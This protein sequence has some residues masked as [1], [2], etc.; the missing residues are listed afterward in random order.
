MSPDSPASDE[1]RRFEEQYRSQPESLVFARLADAY[2]KA[3]QP[4]RALEVLD[5]G[6]LRHPDYPS[7]H[8]V[9]ARALRDLG[10][11]DETLESFRRV[12]ELDGA[13]LV[14]IRELAGLADERGDIRE[15]RHW[16]ERLAHVDPANLEV[17]QR[18][19]ELDAVD[20][21]SQ[22]VERGEIEGAD[23]AS[24]DGD[25]D[26]EGP[27]S[28]WDDSAVTAAADSATGDPG[29][30]EAPGPAV[31][32][33]PADEVRPEDVVDAILNGDVSQAVRAEDTW[34]YEEETD[35]GDPE[36]S[37]DADLLTRTMAD[38]YTEQGLHREAAEIYRELLKDS[39]GD[40]ELVS[41][42]EA[43]REKA[44][45]PTALLPAGDDGSM[46]GEAGEDVEETGDEPATIGRPVGPPWVD[47]LRRL[48]RSGEER[49]GQL[50]EPET[51][52][53]S[54]GDPST[55]ESG[56]PAA[57]PPAADPPDSGKDGLSGSDS[58]PVQPSR[59]A[60]EWIQRL[61][62]EG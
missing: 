3:G 52:D 32:D 28:W 45:D 18:L 20:A 25:A 24:A 38:L 31:A 5:E 40:P 29:W 14:A 22:S 13:N 58:D 8:I 30:D 16:Y 56:Q 44:E 19:R 9:R 4:E 54:P 15:A 42:L 2:R 47:E 7:G 33:D 55:A 51:F 36:P 53:T 17:R 49:A 1:I 34:W 43:V 12:L 39:P 46:Q 10:R 62:A 26:S 61:E 57:D 35:A 50:P 11:V 6:L 23:G 48:L 59:F 60:R 37:K 21:E 27:H 41:R